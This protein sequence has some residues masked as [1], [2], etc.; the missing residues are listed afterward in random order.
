MFSWWERCPI[1]PK[2]ASSI[3]GQGTYLGRGFDP[4]SEYVQEETC[5]ANIQGQ[6]GSWYLGRRK[7]IHRGVGLF[8][9]IHAWVS[10]I[11]C[12]PRVPLH[13]SA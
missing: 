12:K 8:A 10:H 11:C 13:V 7:N 2:V 6:I 4:Q 1:Y 9:S 3:P 5:I